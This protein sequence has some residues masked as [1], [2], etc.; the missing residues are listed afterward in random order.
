M[1]NRFKGAL[2]GLIIGLIFL[3]IYW[4]LGFLIKKF[5]NFEIRHTYGYIG[6][7]IGG[8]IIKRVLLEFIR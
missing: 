8:F 4:L 5:L 3:S 6:C 7:I 1:E 2:E